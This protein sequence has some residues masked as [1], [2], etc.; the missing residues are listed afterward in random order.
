MQ[1]SL[2]NQPS[3][4][5]KFGLKEPPYSTNPDERF[6]YLTPNHQEALAMAVRVI[7]DRE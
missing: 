2:F 4:L 1:K 7:G 3:Y 5:E 6:L